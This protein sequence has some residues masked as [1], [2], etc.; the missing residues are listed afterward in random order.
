MSTLSHEAVCFDSLQK[1]LFFFDDFCGDQ[2]KD[3]WNAGGVGSATVIDLQMGG[4]VRLTTGA[5]TNDLYRIDWNNIRSLLVS[6]KVTIEYRVKLTQ[7]TN[8][9]CLLEL[10]FDATARIFF[11][12]NS[13]VSANWYIVS[14]DTATSTFDS[15]I[16]ADT[17]YHILR[18][19]CHTHGSNHVH[20]YIDGTETANSP[21]TI[22]ANIPDEY[23]DPYLTLL[24]TEDVAK[25]M[26]ID[27]VYIRQ[28]R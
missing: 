13:T 25:S 15:G 28:D 3:E 16:A 24:T 14:S 22:A 4:I 12:Y 20:F 18:I 17:D 5:T 11:T 6:K 27:Y 7:I 2:L 9:R 19:E 23:L 26:D 21:I 8:F 10:I 1:R